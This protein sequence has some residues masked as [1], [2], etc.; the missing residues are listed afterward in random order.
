MEKNFYI[1]L[2]LL[3]KSG[4]YI[5]INISFFIAYFLKF[6]ND[7]SVFGN[8]NYLSFLL[9]FNLAWVVAASVLNTYNYTQANVSTLRTL[10]IIF[11]IILLHLLLVVAFNGVIKTYFSRLFILYTY[12]S[13]VVL[14]LLWRYISLWILVNRAKGKDKVNKVLLIGVE[15]PVKE[16]RDYFSFFLSK[17]LM[18]I[19]K[20]DIAK[21]NEE[22]IIQ[23][24]EKV[25]STEFS[26]VFL[27]VTS[28]GEKHI[29][30]IINYADEHLKNVHLVID[31]PYLNSRHLSLAR[32]GQV[33][34]INI[35]LSPL[36][37][38]ANQL[39]KR[40]FDILFSS[41]V[42]IFILS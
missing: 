21:G 37:S 12:I 17:G 40:A 16:I 42:I 29:I 1:R 19:E 38:I 36:D 18:Q 14:L 39:I 3:R 27:S 28:M 5:L 35:K 41:F 20:I 9:F 30:D 7:L 15:A 23:S 26:E 32:Y 11:R 24:L 6:G 22:E 4:D 8:N 31:E 2:Q 33:P 34:V 25:K 13:I 10:N